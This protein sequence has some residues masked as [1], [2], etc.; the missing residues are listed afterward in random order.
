MLT[1]S[2]IDVADSVAAHYQTLD[3][4][5]GDVTTMSK[6]DIMKILAQ[7]G[8]GIDCGVCDVTALAEN[9]VSE[10]RRNVNDLLHGAIGESGTA[11]QVE[12][13]KVLVYLVLG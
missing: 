2:Q 6:V 7:L 4:V 1:A 12:Y 3:C 8:D 11:C 9:K 13:S 5:I 10:T